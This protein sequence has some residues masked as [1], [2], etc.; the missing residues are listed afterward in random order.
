MLTSVHPVTQAKRCLWEASAT[1]AR[2]GGLPGVHRYHLN[3]GTCC[4]VREDREEPGPAGIVGRLGK[5]QRANHAGNVQILVGDLAIAL[6]QIKRCLVVKVAALIGDSLVK[7]GKTPHGLSTIYAAFLLAR[8]RALRPSEFGLCFAVELGWLDFLS[9]T[10]DEERL[11]AKVDTHGGGGGRLDRFAFGEVAGEDHVPAVS[12]A[13][14]AS[15][16]DR[17]L[18]RPVHLDLH[19]ADALES[20]PSVTGEFGSVADGELYRVKSALAPEA[21]IA[22]FLP[23]LEPAEEG[24]KRPVKAFEGSLARREVTGS[25]V[26]IFKACKLQ[27]GGLFVVADGDLFGIPSVLSSGEGAVVQA[28]VR[29]QKRFH[30]FGLRLRWVQPV[31]ESFDHWSQASLSGLVG[32]TSSIRAARSRSN[33]FMVRSRFRAAMR[34]RR[35]VSLSTSTI[36]RSGAL[37]FSMGRLYRPC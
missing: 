9:F 35:R 15:G 24:S 5:V 3:T 2:L 30:R 6:H 27:D 33:S 34:K 11:Q 13:L 10:G 32:S 4:L 18:N 1:A 28:A 21:G 7:A 26:F 19:V 31:L 22:R 14:E 36:V 20:R 29:F 23:V 25:E 37:A 16:L 12:L 8:Y 17:A